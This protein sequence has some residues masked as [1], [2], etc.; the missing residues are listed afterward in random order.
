[1]N[2]HQ[3]WPHPA[4]VSFDPE[5]TLAALWLKST[6]TTTSA[7]PVGVDDTDTRRYELR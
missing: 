3:E 4:M 6:K 2:F 5:E 7:I 1:M